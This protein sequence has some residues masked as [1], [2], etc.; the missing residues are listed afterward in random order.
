MKFRVF[1]ATL[2]GLAGLFFAGCASQN[3]TKSATM[4]ASGVYELRIYT[5]SPDK[6]DALL[7]R[8]RE[9]TLRLFKKHGV[10]SVGYWLP[11]DQSDQRLHFMLHYPSREARDAAWKG[12]MADPDWQAAYKASEAGGALLARPPENYFLQAT[13]FSPAIKTG[14]VTHGGVFELRTYT[15][16]AGLLPNLDARFRD[17]T[18]ALFAKHGIANY[19]YFHRMADQPDASVTLQYFVTHRSVEAATVAFGDFGKDPEW[20]A[21]KKASEE[22]AGGSL[23]VKDGVKRVF[24][25]PVD[26]SPTK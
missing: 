22:K 14:D 10:E 13:D 9:H 8:F 6:K 1:F 19:A 5:I 26:F 20:I 3:A 15:T 18:V 17:H 11:A 7:A 2:L 4:T 12:F 23:T 21:A 24:L 25:V 16:P